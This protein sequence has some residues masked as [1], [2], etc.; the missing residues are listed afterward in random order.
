MLNSKE[1]T[2]MISQNRKIKSENQ[3]NLLF[4]RMGDFYELF[5]DD[6]VLAAEALNITLTKRGKYLDKD[7]AM[8]GVPVNSY[9]KYLSRLIKLGYKVA[10]CEQ[11]EDPKEAKKKGL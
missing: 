5:F 10:I 2:P 9:E 1:A 6:A 3:N 4:Y 7:I 8:C 11:V